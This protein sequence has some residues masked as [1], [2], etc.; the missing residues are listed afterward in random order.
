MA[1]GFGNGFAS[2]Q[3][4]PGISREETGAWQ[5]CCAHCGRLMAPEEKR[6][7][8]TCGAFICCDCD[9]NDH[10]LGDDV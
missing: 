5:E 10:G 3:V 8:T 7:C 1:Q 4:M 9:E 2:G 6:T